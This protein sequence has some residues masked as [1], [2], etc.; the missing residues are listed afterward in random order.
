M[1]TLF[2]K[3]AL[4]DYTTIK[5]YL[6]LEWG[7]KVVDA[8]EQKTIDFLDLLEQF[9]EA[10]T[11]EVPEKQ[12]RSFLLVKQ[13]RVFYRVKGNQIILLSFFDVRQNPR[14]KPK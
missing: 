11:L 9:P 4:R 2:T 7:A 12:I 14:K 6:T 10:G 5:N 8:F 1:K 3:R 13:I